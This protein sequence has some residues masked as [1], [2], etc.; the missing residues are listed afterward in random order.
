M[1]RLEGGETLGC[2]KTRE[3]EI[4]GEGE[5]GGRERKVREERGRLAL[6]RRGEGGRRRRRTQSKREGGEGIEREGEGGTFSSSSLSSPWPVCQN[7][8]LG[9]DADGGG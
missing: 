8:L 7:S 4:G 3:R 5:Q 6:G 1:V 2:A 9:E